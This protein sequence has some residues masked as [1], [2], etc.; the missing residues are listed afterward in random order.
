MALRFFE[1]VRQYGAVVGNLTRWWTQFLDG[2]SSV[3][4][5]DYFTALPG[6]A[7]LLPGIR[8]GAQRA[9]ARTVPLSTVDG[10]MGFR[11]RHNATSGDG[12][13]ELH[14]FMTEGID[15]GV[16]SNYSISASHTGSSL[17]QYLGSIAGLR[18]GGLEHLVLTI[19]HTGQLSL[20]R[21]GFG[22]LRGPDMAALVA[23]S[24]AAL[25]VDTEHYIEWAWVID[26]TV[27]AVQVWVDGDLW[28]SQTN[29]NTRNVDTA[30][31][32]IGTEV[33][34]GHRAANTGAAATWDYRDLYVFDSAVLPFNTIV[35][36]LGPV[37]IDWDYPTLD[38]A[39]LD[40]TP[41]TA[42]THFDEVD[43]VIPDFDG[44][45]LES[46]TAGHRDSFQHVG[47]PI[48]GATPLAVAVMFLA[49]TTTGASS[50]R[51][52]L[53]IGGTNYDIG[54]AEGNPSTY[55]Y[56]AGVVN[57][58]PSDGTAWSEADYNATEPGVTKV[59]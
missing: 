48:V 45:Y 37:I 5:G 15:Q 32:A 4:L 52:F 20:V 17:T 53:R 1:P 23:T 29:V 35:S 57:L 55:T 8:F 13:A 25:R 2:S 33:F 34:I 56:Q 40:W 6:S 51:P 11:F 38:G 18:T 49:R 46:L 36:R 19:E 31:P 50:T 7:S 27:G 26:A 39:M 58:K 42:T 21:G 9:L 47:L 24:S 22:D 54:A 16:I 12:F 3:T 41:L 30:I 10:G 28:I 43:D 59:T 44:T 14:S